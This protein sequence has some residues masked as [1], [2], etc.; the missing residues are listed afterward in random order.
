MAA[1]P[2][3]TVAMVAWLP[4]A[5]G[6]Y[7]VTSAAWTALEQAIWRRPPAVADR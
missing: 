5:G 4:L 2:F 1:L 7:L 3:L 6:L